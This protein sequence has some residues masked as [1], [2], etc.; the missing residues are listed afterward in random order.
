MM[1]DALLVL[2]HCIRLGRAPYVWAKGALF[3]NPILGRFMRS[4]GGVPVY[5][6][7]KNLAQNAEKDADMT[8]EQQEEFTNRMFEQS[9]KV[10]SHGKLLLL[11]PEGTSYTDTEMQPLR[12][13]VLRVALGFVK[14]HGVSIPII[15][16]GIT[17]FNK[18]RFRRYPLFLCT[19]INML[20]VLIV[21][22][23]FG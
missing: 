9:W 8:K 12:T 10:L 5:R 18:Q 19:P 16:C 17:Y 22:V 14:R 7:T 11:F 13:G 3:S 1:V 4:I 21:F 6:P 15:P 23:W 2:E 20:I